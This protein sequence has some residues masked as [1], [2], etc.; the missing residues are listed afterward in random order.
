MHACA[1]NVK[2]ASSHL[3]LC[4]MALHSSITHHL[5]YAIQE[6]MSDWHVVT[7]VTHGQVQCVGFCWNGAFYQQGASL[8]EAAFSW[9]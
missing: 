2:N 1:C 6:K 7:T 5:Y 8:T 4:E 9:H 3:A